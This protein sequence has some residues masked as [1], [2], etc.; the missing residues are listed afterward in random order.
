M[1]NELM[2]TYSVRL[3][4]NHG[5]PKLEEL[6]E[7]YMKYLLQSGQFEK[8]GQIFEKEGKYEQAVGMYIKSKRLI[9]LPKLLVHHEN[10][11][12]DSTLV[13]NVLKSL[14]KNDLFEGAAEIYEK[15]DKPDMAM[16]CYRK[17]AW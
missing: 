3:A 1:L 11:L 13:T 4:T 9:R 15:L 8:A 2:N 7:E 14:L 6:R 12:E 17:G 10:L 16:Q 5:H